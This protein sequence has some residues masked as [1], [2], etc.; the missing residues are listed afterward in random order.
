MYVDKRLAGIQAVQTLSRLNGIH[1]GKEQTFVLDF[2]NEADEVRE[3]FQQF[4]EGAA[5]DEPVDPQ[6]LY[7]LRH[8]LD[9]F[10]V[11][12][13]HHV[14]AAVFF[15]LGADA[16]LGDHEVG[17]PARPHA[18]PRLQA[19]PRVRPRLTAPT[20][21]DQR[22]SAFRRNRSRSTTTNSPSNAASA[23]SARAT[24]SVSSVTSTR[25]SAVARA[26]TS[27]SVAPGATSRIH[28]TS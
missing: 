12:L 3:A 10:P 27:S 22:G 13:Q 24:R 4:Y 18:R 19:R 14:F 20:R 23:G 16:S 25:S 2:V 1:P 7:E 21:P 17:L 5:T 6:R 11:Y 8:K 26:A 9:A 15:K 28:L